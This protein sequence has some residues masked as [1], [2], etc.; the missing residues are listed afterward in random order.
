ML[1]AAAG[2]LLLA[3]AAFGSY[4][5][6]LVAVVPL[7]VAY[8]RRRLRPVFVAAVAALGVT[9]A[10]AAAGFVWLEGLAATR[11]RYVAGIASSRPY[12]P[13][14]VINL[15]ALAV[16]VGPAIAVA[17]ARLRDRTLWVIVGAALTAIAIADI[18]GMA[19]GE[20]ERIWLPFTPWLLVAGAA[21]TRRQEVTRVRTTRLAPQSGWLALQACTAIAVESVARTA[22]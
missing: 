9:V 22:W 10:F 6:V 17:I 8:R 20:V 3:A 5:V 1:A 11:D 4:G 12:L 16:A 18:S 7:A 14:L 13:F 2:G 15:A 21:L 19:K